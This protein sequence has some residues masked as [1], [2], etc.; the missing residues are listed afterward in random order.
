LLLIEQSSYVLRGVHLC[1]TLFLSLSLSL[2][3]FL[4]LSLYLARERSRR[5]DHC[6][7]ED[8]KEQVGYCQIEQVVV[9]RSLHDGIPPDDDTGNHVAEHAGDE[10]QDVDD[11]D[12]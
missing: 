7:T 8:Q 11:G 10:D 2:S 9:G 1:R 12:G 6:L 3:L 5:R 4:S